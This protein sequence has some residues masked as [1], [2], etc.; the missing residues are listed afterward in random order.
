MSN[1]MDKKLKAYLLTCA[2]N[3]VFKE[4]ISDINNVNTFHLEKNEIDRY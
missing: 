4:N 2:N 3:G 1:D